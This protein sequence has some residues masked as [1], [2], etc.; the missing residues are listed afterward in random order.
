M[1]VSRARFSLL[2]YHTRRRAELLYFIYLRDCLMMLIL[3]AGG[4]DYFVSVIRRRYYG[5]FAAVI[6]VTAP[7]AQAAACSAHKDILTYAFI[8][9]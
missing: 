8:Y 7:R 2:G 5:R 9:E 6:A 1:R 3:R 4:D